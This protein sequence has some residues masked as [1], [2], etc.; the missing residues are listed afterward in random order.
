MSKLYNIDSEI[1]NNAKDNLLSNQK[2]F[3][4]VYPEDENL[5]LSKLNDDI[6]ESNYNSYSE[7]TFNNGLSVVK[8]SIFFL[9]HW[10]KQFQSDIAKNLVKKIL[11]PN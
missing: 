1:S 4:N 2:S 9:C 8:S 11:H 6:R 7:M 10:T 3:N 5:V